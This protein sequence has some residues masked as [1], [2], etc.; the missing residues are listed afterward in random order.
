MRSVLLHKRNP[1]VNLSKTRQS[2]RRGMVAGVSDL[3]GTEI[4]ISRCCSHVLY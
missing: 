3:E 2:L 4:Y 1:V